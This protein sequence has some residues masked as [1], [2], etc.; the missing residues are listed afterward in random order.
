METRGCVA[1]YDP[2]TEEL[3]YYVAT[4]S[5]HGVRF[6]ALSSLEPTTAPAWWQ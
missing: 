5:P 2:G 1:H 6:A 4:Q 3:T